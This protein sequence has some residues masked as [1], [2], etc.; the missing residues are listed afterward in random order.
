MK[1]KDIFLKFKEQGK[2]SDP[3]YDAIL[4]KIPDGE[5]PDKLFKLIEDN[6]LTRERAVTDPQVSKEIWGKAL[7][8]VDKEIE[9]FI[10]ILDPID[11]ALA[12]ETKSLT[13]DLGNGKV[14]PD[15]FRQLE[16]L[17]SSLPGVLDKIK[18]TPAQDEDSKKKVKQLETTIQE[19]TDKFTTL[20]ND[21]KKNV[22]TVQDDYEKK[23]HDYKLDGEL[24]KLG[25][26]FTLAE[27]YDKNRQ[28]ISKVLMTD[29]KALHALKLGEK[30]GQPFIQ[31]LDDKGQPKFNGNT[32]VTINEL[33]TEKYKPFLKQSNGDHSQSQ[34]KKQSFTVD[35]SKKDVR[36]GA[37]T[38]VE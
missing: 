32:P 21:H 22:K 5:F 34:E 15:T 36:R 14:V 38:T 23:F 6:F 2:I 28:A 20:E 19:M 30:D 31:V 27:A 18:A 33:L 29:I 24:D 11:R 37:R 13:K 8:P 17:R 9:N 10:N 1:L 16:K 7:W 35:T 4:D 25:N 3:E 26:S 12:L